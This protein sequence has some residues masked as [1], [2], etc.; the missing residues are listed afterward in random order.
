M[1]R[2]FSIFTQVIAVV[3]VCAMCMVIV[4]SALYADECEY[5][6]TQMKQSA[7]VVIGICGITGVNCAHAIVAKNLWSGAR[8]LVGLVGCAGAVWR[9]VSDI[10][11]Y[12]NCKKGTASLPHYSLPIMLRQVLS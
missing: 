11:S 10:I 5:E 8:C 2:Q 12:K 1:S 9:L 3:L 6:R 7:L 4:P